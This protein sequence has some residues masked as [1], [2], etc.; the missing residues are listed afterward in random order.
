MLKFQKIMKHY[1][2]YFIFLIAFFACTEAKAQ[3]PFPKD[4]CG[5]EQEKEL[6]LPKYADFTV[7][8]TLYIL[9]P[10]RVGGETCPSYIDSIEHFLPA[11][12]YN[13]SPK[14]E[15]MVTYPQQYSRNPQQLNTVDR[16]IF[17]KPLKINDKIIQNWNGKIIVNK[18][19]SIGSDD[20]TFTVKS[21]AD[22]GVPI[23][24][25]LDQSEYTLYTEYEKSE[26]Y[27]KT[28]MPWIFKPFTP[29]VD[30][31]I[32]TTGIDIEKFGIKGADG[33]DGA[34]IVAATDG[35]P[36]GKGVDNTFT[37]VN[38]PHATFPMALVPDGIGINL[39]STGGYGGRGGKEYFSWTNGGKGGNGG[40]GGNVTLDLR[41]SDHKSQ[42][43]LHITGPYNKQYSPGIQLYSK[44]GTGGPGG[45][46]FLT[47][48]GGDGG[49]TA[50]GGDIYL[51]GYGTNPLTPDTTPV[52]S[53]YAKNSW[54]I[55]ANSASNNGGDGGAQYGLVGSSGSG[56]GSG[57]GGNV[58]IQ[59]AFS[60]TTSGLGSHGILASS[61][62]GNGG[63]SGT[64]INAFV[65]MATKG[66]DG[67]NG[68]NVTVKN[69]GSIDTNADFSTG[70]TASSH[71]GGGGSNA[72]E[73]SGLINFGGSNSGTGGKGGTVNISNGGKITTKGRQS[74][75]IVAS[76]I[77]G[78]GGMNKYTA[79]APFDTADYLTYGGTLPGSSGSGMPAG[80][81]IIFSGMNPINNISS[82][83]IHTQGIEAHGI[84]AM[85]L[86]GGG[87]DSGQQFGFVAAIGGK[88]GSGHNG[89]TITINHS[90]NIETIGGSS[91]GIYAHSTGGGGGNGILSADLAIPL[92]TAQFGIAIGGSGGNSGN[93]GNIDLILNKYAASNFSTT[94]TAIF[95]S[96]IGGGGG[97]GGGA[98]TTAAGNSPVDVSVS[99]GGNGGTGG[100]GGNITL[101]SENQV[102][103]VASIATGESGNGYLD[104]KNSWDSMRNGI[105]LVSKG[106][107]GGMG[108]YAISQNL[109]ANAANSK[110]TL[111]YS[112]GGKGSKGGSSGNIIIGKD[113]PKD[114]KSTTDF[115][116]VLPGF[117]GSI[118]T[119][120]AKSNGIYAYSTGGGGG[121]GGLAYSGI[122]D[123][124]S[125]TDS[126]N[127][128]DA[129]ITHGG[130]GGTGGTSGAI[131]ISSPAKITTA[132]ASSIGIFAHSLAGGGGNGGLTISSTL[133]KGGNSNVSV[134]IG[135]SAGS[136]NTSGPVVVLR[137]S[138]SNVAKSI[139]T[140][141]MNSGGISASSIGG[142]GGHNS[143]DVN[144]TL[145]IP[146]A[147]EG[148]MA[149]TN[150]DIGGKSGKGGNSNFIL[151][152]NFSDISSC[153]NEKECS[154]SPGIIASS[155]AGGGGNAVSNLIYNF[156]VPDGKLTPTKS[157]SHKLQ[158]SVGGD[159][160][161]G[162][163][164][165]DVSV[166]QQ[167]SIS[168]GNSN[169]TSGGSSHGILAQS[170]GGGGGNVHSTSVTSNP[171]IIKEFAHKDSIAVNLGA[172]GGAG[173]DSGD[174]NI[175]INLDSIT[176]KVATFDG[177]S[178]GIIGQSI[179]GGGGTSSISSITVTK[180]ST[181]DHK[182]SLGVRF[183]E[184]PSAVGGTSGAV[185]ISNSGLV[186]VSGKSSNGIIG[187]S[188]S[189][190]G[191]DAGL[192]VGT[193]LSNEYSGQFNFGG[194][195]GIAG[196]SGPVNI[197]NMGKV[198]TMGDISN[199]ILAQSISGGG[200]NGS[201]IN[202]FKVLP[203]KAS[204]GISHGGSGGSGGQSGI[205]SAVN[206]GDINTNGM[207]SH[208]ILAQSIGGG[209]GSGGSIHTV[210]A[211]LPSK[212]T[213]RNGD[214]KSNMKLGATY[215]GKGGTGGKSNNVSVSNSGPIV[216]LKDNS[217]GI[218]GQS[219]GG[220]GGQA[221]ILWDLSK[222]QNKDTTQN[223]SFAVDLGGSGGTAA[224]GFKTAI[225][226]ELNGSIT[227]SGIHSHGISA[228]SIGGGGGNGSTIVKLDGE[229]PKLG[230]LSAT[231]AV[232]GSGGAGGDGGFVSVTN[233]GEIT[234]NGE[235]S[236]AIS[237]LSIGGGGG[238]AGMVVNIKSN[239]PLNF[240]KNANIF[241]IG[242]IGGS[243]GSSVSKDPNVSAIVS[244][245]NDSSGSIFLNNNKQIG[246]KAQSIGGGGG[247]ASLVVSLDGD[248][249]KN[250]TLKNQVS[251]FAL[252][253]NGGKGGD[254]GM[255]SII[256]S[257]KISASGD[258]SY[259]I[260]GQSVSGGGGH[261]SYAFSSILGSAITS[262]IYASHGGQHYD[263]TKGTSGD[264]VVTNSGDIIIKGQRSTPIY[265]STI[266]GGGGDS[267]YTIRML[268][269]T[270]H[271]YNTSFN[272]NYQ[273][274]SAGCKIVDL[275]T[276]CKPEASQSQISS[277]ITPDTTS[278]DSAVTGSVRLTNSGT[279]S[280]TGYNSSGIHLQSIAG[281]G[282]KVSHNHILS[283]TKSKFKINLGSLSSLALNPAAG[284]IDLDH[285]GTVLTDGRFS[286]AVLVQS[287]GGGGG[288]SSVYQSDSNNRDKH[289]LSYALG[290]NK[291][292]QSDGGKI[293]V[294]LTNSAN[295][296][297][298]SDSCSV[299][300]ESDYSPGVFLQSIG[301][302]GGLLQ[303]DNYSLDSQVSPGDINSIG[304]GA[305]IIFSNDIPI[306]TE[307]LFSSAILAQSI[308]GGGGAVFHTSTSDIPS[309]IT[310][311]A[312]RVG[313]GGN[314]NISQNSPIELYSNSSAIFAQSV[315]GGGGLI[316]DKTYQS[317]G[318][319]RSG[320]VEISVNS[321]IKLTD[322]NDAP[323]IY[324][325]SKATNKD[326]Q[327]DIVI[328]VTSGGKITA[329]NPIVV[330]GGKN[331][332]IQNSGYLSSYSP[333]DSSHGLVLK[334]NHGNE[335]I[336]NLAGGTIIGNLELGEGNNQVVNHSGAVFA[337][338]GE[339]FTGNGVNS[340]INHGYLRSAKE[341]QTRAKS[342]M[343][344]GAYNM[345]KNDSLN[346]LNFKGSFTQ[347]QTGVF[348]VD[349]DFKSNHNTS[350]HV[351]G[352][353][354]VDGSVIVSPVNHDHVVPGYYSLDILS[355][356]GNSS[357]SNISF[358]KPAILKHQ[359]VEKDKSLSLSYEVD[360]AGHALLGDNHSSIGSHINSILSNKNFDDHKLGNLLEAIFDTKSLD[361]L[362]D[363]Y[364][365][366][367]PEAYGSSFNLTRI[368]NTKFLASLFN[369][370]SVTGISSFDTGE[371][372]WFDT[373]FG[374][375]SQKSVN[376][377]LGYDSNLSSFSVGSQLSLGNNYYFG[378]ALS[379]LDTFTFFPSS[380]LPNTSV[381]IVGESWNT[382]LS[383]MKIIDRTKL[384]FGASLSQAVFDS[385]RNLFHVADSAK[386]SQELWSYSAELI[387]S[388]DIDLDSDVYLRPSLGLG[389]Q[390][391]NQSAFSEYGAGPLNLDISSSSQGYLNLSPAIQLG[392]SY[393]YKN[394]SFSP[395]L[396][397]G[398]IS[399]FGDENS[400]NARFSSSKA[401]VDSFSIDPF[402]DDNYLSGELGFDLEFNSGFTA[403]LSYSIEA[404]VNSSYNSGSI[405][406]SIPF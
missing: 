269:D 362:S 11:H 63:H 127:A 342:P 64:E 191:G 277:A 245:S 50:N 302:G 15:I 282:G 317:G 228:S 297:T 122:I 33:T 292:N 246:I 128:L 161:G 215:S 354:S 226:N 205:V 9:N 386:G 179:A 329:K 327:G 355:A 218:V 190:G 255:V 199:G 25:Q 280:S 273:V 169:S 290:A 1:T 148:G 398:L 268:T 231:L 186:S 177:S 85:S 222:T 60:I 393:Q 149:T 247:N 311:E 19:V 310:A 24:Y 162:G 262:T 165:E 163:K 201:S 376:D 372:G 299:A 225:N 126:N 42:I 223:R 47:P 353:A 335:S 385:S 98:I 185:K 198:T 187:Q 267:S 31:T 70:I 319:G 375:L 291:T 150:I 88:G 323:A 326:D 278:A 30:P 343:L 145:S 51:Y 77:G 189:G 331:N 300:T 100:N 211:E 367:S 379:Y 357:F 173:G 358:I 82:G 216:T 270:A 104:E 193:D 350:L 96:S 147:G 294:A 234:I 37:A 35:K 97:I 62:G 160:G 308:G 103:Y 21:S 264:V 16:Y 135:G 129:T 346:Q 112:Q 304:N 279:I 113:F 137:G 76:S 374:Q 251:T 39:G 52:I 227:T 68:G 252:G 40:I 69:V 261:G 4:E 390:F 345:K 7:E 371:C 12:K 370:S 99:K 380:S 167:G 80:D 79:V 143:L 27:Y 182:H 203:G 298:S 340:F 131:L 92:S 111:A 307:G 132:A 295:K 333:S 176:S 141:G 86:G 288:S 71:G 243:G 56:G 36:G 378:A 26:S 43:P 192:I 20:S 110:V 102:K 59:S 109:K 197:V 322:S 404:S 48:G 274:G 144:A 174:I 235:S 212:V 305:D 257:G 258:D 106:G 351:N 403:S 260:Y 221:G 170:I 17:L 125:S 347:S 232:G 196:I 344:S 119:F 171:L 123:S 352:D 87:G 83:S 313:N 405:S 388:Q 328:T 356:T 133:I 253:G 392:A 58:N 67:G 207:N 254:S 55:F 373:S 236:N 368:S 101:T 195:G 184:H 180:G 117:L 259:G 271:N 320:N 28:F 286:P 108:G 181:K 281:G 209:G 38:Q 330:D 382:G 34:V 341:L 275:N 230:D 266:T 45:T 136:G 168:T 250:P 14:R 41:T 306:S 118:N 210:Q 249:F 241:S 107:G 217:I 94:D 114:L 406:F 105:T 74:S 138:T 394:F 49:G 401:S 183:Q 46:G 239:L 240:H 377:S 29:N 369:C 349:H 256:N 140:T 381:S 213:G 175:N 233:R 18:V 366:L 315:G 402:Y 283:G 121:D 116:K 95:A 178:H 146:S 153:L 5:T 364:L 172:Q 248:S 66:G 287:I 361:Q 395:R 81:I 204:I 312:S 91:K 152:N 391:I 3:S 93:G 229:T 130:N 383:L 154:N 337:S 387:V 314:I 334:A 158:Y 219:I 72:V 272:T 6:T 339:L 188:I 284:N 10:F 200:G 400:L 289:T 325:S 301:G 89:G 321:T 120:Q 338:P 242:K 84:S 276:P 318:K 32:N 360:Y 13:N 293:H 139:T 75:G 265:K 316:N 54:G 389:Y 396:R 157:T 237:A 332:Q 244:V 2:L 202:S 214:Q 224:T 124:K 220:G 194:S 90:G 61:M 155:L 166:T 73:G 238:N 263:G 134:N 324:A 303:V 206:S 348:Q 53:T 23:I 142:G 57:S 285:T 399:Y 397:I 65:S 359:F 8:K 151:V 208:G 363:A 365:S 384:S 78:V 164:S 309:L 159:A 336:H 156:T 296:C 22:A 115:T 44:S